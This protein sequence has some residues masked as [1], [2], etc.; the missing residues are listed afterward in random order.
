MSAGHLAEGCNQERVLDLCAAPGGKTTQIAA[1]MKGEG[2]LVA[3]EI[4]SARARILSQNVER[5]GIGNCAVTN[6][7]PQQLAERFPAYFDT[8]L[9]DAPCS[10]EGMF[11]KEP[12]AIPE[13]NDKNVARCAG[14]QK[15]I[16]DC[17]AEMLAAGGSLVYSTCTFAEEE[18]EWQVKDFL[19]R[20]P[21]FAL[22]AQEKYYPHREK[23][24]GHFCARL[25]KTDGSRVGTK[26]YP[27]RRN[28]A[29]NAAYRV[30]AE[31]F[32]S[33]PPKGEIT[34]L[35]D[36]RL[37]LVPRGMPDFGSVR[38]LRLGVELGEFDGKL[39]KPAHALVMAY[40]A[41]ARRKVKLSREESLKF[42]RGEPIEADIKNGWAVVCVEEFP[43][44]LGK[45]VNGT[46][47][48]HLPKGLRMI[49]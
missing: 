29:A 26:P 33:E 10:G 21:D 8:V 36:G 41:S 34:T 19:A 42:L 45:A 30:F 35:A 4:E 31:D 32:F 24:E 49:K 22:E 16:L 20:H 17:A 37:Y 27:V 47:K 18:D 23:G 44:G 39:F 43:I 46:V 15:E 28:A 1:Q 48:N 14:R 9:V 11:K 3:N 40:G 2:I 6:A 13:W 12:N 7:S 5:M 38:L 25:K